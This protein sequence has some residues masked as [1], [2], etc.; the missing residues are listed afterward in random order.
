M[1]DSQVVKETAASV[2]A[3]ESSESEE[4]AVEAKAASEENTPEAEAGEEAKE[5]QT[6][7]AGD[8]A[9]QPK[10][11]GPTVSEKLFTDLDLPDSLQEALKEMGY[12]HP[13]DV[14]IAAMEPG[15]AGKDL[16]VQAKTGS[17]KTTAFGIPLVGRLKDNQAESRKP[18]AIVLVPTR[19]LAHQVA[20]EFRELCEGSSLKVFAVYGGVSIGR[21]AGALKGGVDIVV[22]TPGRL[23]DHLRLHRFLDVSRYTSDNDCMP[24]RQSHNRSP[25][26]AIR[27]N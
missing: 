19:E 16:V 5:A 15:L 11:K 6:E 20:K 23:L 26:N 1:T 21:Q 18:R 24:G 13:T 12:V 27:D 22:G 14:Q 25:H 17:G 3:S 2:D 8:E 10:A 7:A 4:E 9:E